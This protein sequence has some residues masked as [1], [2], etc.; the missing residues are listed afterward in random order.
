MKIP[1]LNLKEI[2]RP[3]ID[4]F[5]SITK[6]FLEKGW[7]ILG[8]GVK[9]FENQFKNYCGTK[10]CVGVAN[11]LDALELIFKGYLELGKLKHGDEVLVPANTYIASILSVT[12]NGLKPIFI[13]PD[14]DYNISPSNIKKNIN[15]KTK[16][17][18]C[19]HLYGRLCKMD[20]IK[21]IA[22]EFNLILVEDSAQS[23]GAILNG[24]RSGS[25]GDASGFSF[26]PGKNLGCLG[27][28]GAITTDNYELYKV[29]NQLR[30]YGSEKKYHNI[31]KGVNSRLDE[32]QALFLTEKLKNLD[33]D[34]DKRVFIAN[35][36]LNNIKNIKIKL[37]PK[38]E[39]GCHVWHL[40]TIL[41]QER[42][43]FIDYLNKNGIQ[44]VIHYPIPPHK[45]K[46]YSEYGQLNLPVTE[47]IHN[48]TV[49]IPMDPTLSD[50]NIE[51]IIDKINN[52]N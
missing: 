8:D 5:T 28:G 41:T 51:Y 34:N 24:E 9:D 46:A 32:I 39:E 47:K 7:Y 19:V 35:K 26:Y 18:L 2:N 49:S 3:Y 50:T 20:Q 33:I 37:P 48:Q 1:F 52:Y 43:L 23:H 11:G 10:Y 31:V 12:N 40:F 25:F 6:I 45:Q 38:F 29:I 30:N 42:D 22:N 4:T 15:S 44:T 36:Y 27:D 13:E 21:T 16:A 17:I 14:E